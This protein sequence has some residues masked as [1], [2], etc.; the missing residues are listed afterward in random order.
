MTKFTSFDDFRITPG[1]D[2]LRLTDI[3]WTGMVEITMLA[4]TD[5]M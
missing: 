3:M 5:I 2:Q 4:Q 1:V